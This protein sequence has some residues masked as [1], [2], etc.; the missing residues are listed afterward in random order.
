M[1]QFTV[2]T[3]I[4]VM[5]VLGG[6]GSIPGVAVGAL[7]L[8]IFQSLVLGGLNQ[9]AHALGNA[10]RRGRAEDPRPDPGQPADLRR[11]AG[12]DDALP[13]PGAHPRATVRRR[14]QR[15]RADRPGRPWRLQAE[16]SSSPSGTPPR[17][18]ASRCSRSRACSSAL[19]AWSRPTTSTWSSTPVQIVSVIGPNGSGKTT[20][21]NM[22]TGL[23]RPDGGTRDV[24]RHRHH[25]PAA[26]QD[27]LAG[28]H[29]HLPE[30]APVQQPERDG[31]RADR[32]ARPPQRGHAGV[33]AAD[34]D[35]C[36]ARRPAR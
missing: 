21:F 2:S 29:A 27:R 17:S 20:L 28:H 1:F 23:V 7:I 19:A 10:Y 30:P 32:P 25:P 4:L 11:R 9:W 26:A 13:P 36:A 35:A 6:M 8:T 3:I 12:G 18:R 5:V 31:E 16:R 15:Q 14:A 24:P 33:R 22:L 34:A